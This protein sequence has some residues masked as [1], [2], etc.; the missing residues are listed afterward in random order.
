MFFGRIRNS[1][2]FSG[3]IP[4]AFL[5]LAYTI[6]YTY[7]KLVQ[8]SSQILTYWPY[9]FISLALSAA[10][11]LATILYIWYLAT[12]FPIRLIVIPTSLILS[13]I[14]FLY[15]YIAPLTSLTH[16]TLRSLPFLAR[17][18]LHLIYSSPRSFLSIA[19]LIVALGV[20][21][22]LWRFTGKRNVA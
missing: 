20:V 3:T 10:F 1:S 16:Y 5:A 12:T 7:V 9:W 2:L 17:L 6:D 19:S 22:T 14:I 13:L 15:R 8:E 21:V 4:L 11:A 18:H